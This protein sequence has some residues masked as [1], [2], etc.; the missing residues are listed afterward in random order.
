ME[1]K[2]YRDVGIFFALSL[3]HGGPPPKFMS[4]TL[5]NAL[6]MRTGKCEA[7]IDDISDGDL[8]AEVLKV[9]IYLF[10]FEHN[11]ITL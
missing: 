4:T 2:L 3:V 10:P 8:K 1:D 11:V 7:T 6:A 9:F 5:Y